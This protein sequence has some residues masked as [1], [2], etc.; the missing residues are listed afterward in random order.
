M[1]LEGFAVTVEQILKH[2]NCLKDIVNRSGVDLRI[3][4]VDEGDER[5]EMRHQNNIISSI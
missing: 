5:L 2:F 1:F 4:E 3:D